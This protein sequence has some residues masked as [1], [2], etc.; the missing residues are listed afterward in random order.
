MIQSL[1]A[2]QMKQKNL[3]ESV[4]DFDTLSEYEK[5][6]LAPSYRRKIKRDSGD[7]P[8]PRSELI[9]PV[10]K[11]EYFEDTDQHKRY[12]DIA[13]IFIMRG[14]FGKAK[15]YEILSSRDFV[16]DF[17]TMPRDLFY[18]NEYEY[19]EWRKNNQQ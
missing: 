14:E 18:I 2:S 12:Y 17:E 11:D 5:S 19:Y 7:V 1:T 6:V 4:F 8:I 15:E 3:M 13:K 16:K 10:T 9:K